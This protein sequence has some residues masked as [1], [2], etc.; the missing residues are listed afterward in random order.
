MAVGYT[1]IPLLVFGFFSGFLM[2]D[3]GN[4]GLWMAATLS[5]SVLV[6]I[7]IYIYSTVSDMSYLTLIQ[8]SKYCLNLNR[9]MRVEGLLLCWDAAVQWAIF[10]VIVS[11]AS[12]GP[13]SD[14]TLGDDD[15]ADLVADGVHVAI[16]TWGLMAPIGSGVI[17]VVCTLFAA[18]EVG[19]GLRK[20]TVGGFDRHSMDAAP[21][22][23]SVLRAVVHACVTTP[24]RA[25]GLGEGRQL[26]QTDAFRSSQ[27]F[28]RVTKTKL[29]L[30][31]II[32]ILCM[33][34]LG[35]VVSDVESSRDALEVYG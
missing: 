21:S 12:S 25:F 29:A 30:H 20:G 3:L 34:F 31:L 17:A 26:D 15:T 18:L 14:E 6:I 8:R 10:V 27:K 1:W 24:S 19:E 22:P 2:W 32:F 9:W 11:S 33:M 35:P 28:L 7:G 23:P 4:I 5:R 13:S 16:H